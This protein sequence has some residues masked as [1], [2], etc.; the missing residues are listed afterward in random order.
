MSSNNFTADIS[1]SDGSSV[2]ERWA[3]IEGDDIPYL[4]AGNSER[5]VLLVHGAGANRTDWMDVIPVLAS[6][7]SVYAP[8]LI[9][10]GETPRR[11]SPHTPEYIAN[12]LA[13]FMDAAGIEKAALVGHSLGGRVC[14]EMAR[15]HP[16]RVS[17][18]VLEAPMG[19]GKVAWPGRMF[20][21]A[22]WWIHKI[23]GLRSPYPRLDF[24]PVESDPT[25]F[26]SLNCKTLM[27]WGANDLYFPVERGRIALDLIPNS[28]LKVYER[29]GHSAHRSVPARFNSD[30]TAFLANVV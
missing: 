17:G 24:P 16:E 4:S 29:V 14:L 21:M 12:F 15:R 8:D 10:F 11:E 6:D 18:L 30:V 28:T 1:T 20:S 5:R 9:G 25:G 22:R 23:A 13:G 2:V 26:D 27:L 19:F 3:S 7:N